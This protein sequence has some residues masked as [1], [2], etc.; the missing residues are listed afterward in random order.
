MQVNNAALVFDGVM[1]LVLL[2]VFGLGGCEVRE[3][4]L[5]ALAID[6][7]VFSS[8]FDIFKG[9]P[10]VVRSSLTLNYHLRRSCV[11]LMLPNFS[12]V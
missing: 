7:L 8:D 2:L 1:R 10:I 9:G 4:Y 6:G 11:A 5:L 12:I 3:L